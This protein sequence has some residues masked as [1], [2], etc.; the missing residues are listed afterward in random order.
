MKFY[1]SATTIMVTK[2]DIRDNISYRQKGVEAYSDDT[3]GR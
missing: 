3:N 1:I 2:S